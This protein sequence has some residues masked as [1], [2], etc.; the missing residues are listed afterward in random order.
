MRLLIVGALEGYLTK[1]SSVARAR[2]CQI[3][4]VDEP[5]SALEMLRGDVAFDLVLIDDQ[6]DIPSFG[7]AL[8]EE[9][10]AVTFVACGLGA[11][12]KHAV[13]AIKGGAAEYLPLPPDPDIIA[14]L[15][16]SAVEDRNSMIYRSDAMTKVIATADKIASS[17]ASVLILGESGTG[18]EV[19]AR[20]IH[21]HSKRKGKAFIAVNC[22]AIPETLLESELFGHERGAFSG[23]IARRFGKF[24][25]ASGG[26]LLLDE[27]SEMDIGLQ[28]KLLRAI[29]EREIDRL[30][31]S[32][33]IKVNVRILATSNRDLRAM[34]AEGRFRE[35]LYFRLNVVSL[36][37]PPLRERR[38][39][40]ALLAQHFAR[41][42]T[43][44]DDLPP[45]SFSQDALDFLEEQDWHGNI[46][47]LE[48]AT[49]R[50]VLLSEGS[51]LDAQGFA[52]TTSQRGNANGSADSLQASAPDNSKKSIGKN[53]GKETSDGRSD[54]DDGGS[55]LATIEREAVL[56]TITSSQGNYEQAASILGIS[57][58]MLRMKLNRYAN[59]G[60]SIP[61][62]SHSGS[63]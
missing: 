13:A 40:I 14:S 47:E 32:S 35:D 7:R 63:R 8:S 43:E 38:G 31:G 28:A 55:N 42:Y 16:E 24:E 49:H 62:H 3:H 58:R 39:D 60:H 56:R 27:I 25:Q 4:H 15:L 12:A 46:R 45:R 48:N 50:A 10:I 6:C 61:Q 1:A 22:A 21:S 36:T 5:S 54:T 9:R 18:K 41:K 23:A 2:G 53:N 59:E 30:G 44:E 34:C 33:P 51:S 19:I 26:T 52:N 11:D 17:D 20:H 29:Q 37:L 57:I